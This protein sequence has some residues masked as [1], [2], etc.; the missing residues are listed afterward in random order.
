MQVTS[1]PT[2]VDFETEAI[3]EGAGVAPCPVGVSI[4]HQYY[5]WGHPTNNNCTFEDARRKLASVWDQPLLFHNGK[6]DIN[7]AMEH[8]GLPWPKTWHDTMFLVYL[9]N[10]IAPSLSLKPSAYR[11]LG[12]PPEEQEI[13]RDWLIARGIVSSNTK[14]WGAHISKAPGDLVGM[15]AVGDTMRTELLFHRLYKSVVDRGMH[16]AYLREIQLTPILS[17]AEKHGVRI[18]RERLIQDYILYQKHFDQ[19]NKKV[20]SKLNCEFNIDS[21]AELARA[22]ERS[23]L[24][25]NLPRTPTGRLSTARSALESAVNDAELLAVLRYRGALKTLL[26]TFM[27]PWLELSEKDGRLH[28]SWNQ[29]KG[30]VYGTR[31]GRLSCSSPNL[32]NVPTEFEGLDLE[33]CPSLPFMRRYILP[34]DGHILVAADYN[35]QEMRLLAHFAEGRA[36]EIYR[37]DPR[38]DFHQVARDILLNE[39]GLDLKRKYVKIT[40]FSLIYGAGV[41]A[42][43]A[44]L[45]LPPDQARQIRDNYLN[46]MPGLREFQRDVSSRSQIRTWG[47]RIIPVEPPKMVDGQVWSFEY[48]LVNH[49][50]QG[51]AAD[52]TKQSIVGFHK[53][54]SKNS[55]FLMTV[56][57][58]NVISVLNDPDVIS[59]E[60]NELRQAMEGLPGFDVPFVA[61]VEIGP[62]WHDLEEY[63]G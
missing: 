48:K 20:W 17:D 53:T 29:V 21:G 46:A 41:P 15:Y 36:A 56:H 14:S 30:D 13:V 60:I 23:G 31:T 10:P 35:G 52:Q 12:M 9:D 40:G 37:N 1:P 45:G 24:V 28:P 55:R 7:V 6:F 2:V 39:A 43:A 59:K 34:D 44:Q 18:D 16:D 22:L 51:S 47:G 54:K 42:L 27:S 26:S 50:I 32:Q 62:N 25:S 57:D 49:L 3:Q 33:G 4:N 63:H 11:L 61:E 19:L 5:S 38:A 58:E 8:M